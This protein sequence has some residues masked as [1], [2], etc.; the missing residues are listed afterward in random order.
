MPLSKIITYGNFYNRIENR[1]KQVENFKHD[2]QTLIE[3]AIYKGLEIFVQAIGTLKPDHTTHDQVTVTGGTAAKNCELDLSSL[4]VYDIV[5]IT[6]GMGKLYHQADNLKEFI[7][8][9]SDTSHAAKDE[10]RYWFFERGNDDVVQLF[11]GTKAIAA[12]EKDLNVWYV[13]YPDFSDFTMDNVRAN[14]VK[15]DMVDW[16]IPFW[17]RATAIDLIREQNLDVP[18]NLLDDAEKALMNVS[19]RISRDEM[20]AMQ[21][22]LD[23]LRK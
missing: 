6:Y 20:M 21:A 11:M 8:K 18:Q 16:I 15:C 22:N 19:D 12:A 3:V 9:Q 14:T 4:N 1:T 17:M 7:Q 23:S 10:G 2:E 13:R 5:E